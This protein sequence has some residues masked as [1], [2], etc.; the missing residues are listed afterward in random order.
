MGTVNRKLLTP[1]QCLPQ[2]EQT[3]LSGTLENTGTGTGTGTPITL[4]YNFLF[5]TNDIQEETFS[6]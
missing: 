6:R 4:M 2:G 3:S 5:P 1:V